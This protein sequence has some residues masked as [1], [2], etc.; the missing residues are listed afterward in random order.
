MCDPGR[1][2]VEEHRGSWGGGGGLWDPVGRDWGQRSWRPGDWS[3]VGWSARAPSAAALLAGLGGPRPGERWVGPS[4]LV[5]G[6]LV[7]RP[8]PRKPLIACVE[9]Q[10]LGEHLTAILQKGRL[11]ASRACSDRL[12]CIQ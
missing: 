12:S 8:P 5:D 7:P 9:K 1:T 10:L 3:S 6:L 2:Q 4:L 11:P